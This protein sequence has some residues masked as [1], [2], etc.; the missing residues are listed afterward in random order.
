MSDEKVIGVKW[1]LSAFFPEFNGHEMITMKK[2]ISDGVKL[3]QNEA[4]RLK[5]LSENTADQWEDLFIKTEVL[6]SELDHIYCYVYCLSS[7][8]AKNEEYLKEISALA[9][10]NAE[11][12]KLD[13][14]LMRALKDT[15][16]VFFS[17]FINR[18]RLKDVGYQIIRL[19]EKSQKTM[20]RELEKLA[21]DLNADG[22]HA[23]SRL[24]DII[25][26]KLEFNM[27]M[28]DG[29]TIK[30]PISEWRSLMADADRE[31]GRAAFEGGNKAWET[32][33]DTCAAILNSIAGT[34]FTLYRYRG[35]EDYL[36]IPLFQSGITRKTLDAMYEATKENLYL[37][38]E[39]LRVK[40]DF[41]RR[42]SIWWYERE[43]P[44]PL[45]DSEE[46][47]WED[48]VEMI[49]NAFSKAYPKFGDYFRKLISNNCVESEARGGKR[50]GA[51]C[52]STSLKNIERIYMTFNRSI[53]DITTLAHE[54]GHAFHGSLM[55][56]LRPMARNYPMTLAETA[57]TFGEKIL[58][59]SILSDNSISDKQ[60]L[61]MLD[62]SI[63]DAAIYLLDITVRFEFEKQFHEQR[64][65]GELSVSDIK[66]MMIES[67]KNVM[68]D[69]LADGGEDPMFWASKLHFYKTSVSFYNYPYTFGY[70]FSSAVYKMFKQQGELFL[71]KYEE[72]LRQSGSGSVEDVALRVLN[73]NIQDPKFWSDTIQALK[74]PLDAYRY[75]LSNLKK[76]EHNKS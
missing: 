3:L 10:L 8:N 72:F 68:Q 73:I 44:I 38:R 57:S 9:K 47:L 48:G 4:L 36:E 55:H 26:G 31:V 58:A 40:A 45:E 60:K 34:R 27:V 33:E 1:D 46:Y 51:F 67:Q 2:E 11:F 76:I 41:M 15:D 29:K 39:I 7:A 32:I 53:N 21:A 23:W 66:N 52:Y 70:L 18:E 20:P 12:N 49:Q 35:I 59:Q 16:D 19:R 17:A 13:V 22:F 63:S 30:K 28:P 69:V 62:A 5:K 65:R 75:L 6:E 25:T 56:D 71:P 43:A 61:L 64:Q 74:E 42:D 50:P 14:D 24:Y 54:S 37:A